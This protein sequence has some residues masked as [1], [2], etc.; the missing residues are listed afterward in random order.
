MGRRNEKEGEV[1]FKLIEQAIIII[2]VIAI[3]ITLILR[4]LY[5]A[6]TDYIIITSAI[7]IPYLIVKGVR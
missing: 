7:L 6:I 4:L 1:M 2:T 3:L 5:P